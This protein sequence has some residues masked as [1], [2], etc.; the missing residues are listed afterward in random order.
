MSDNP[1][2]VRYRRGRSIES[3]HRGAV[4]LV[5]GDRITMQLGDPM[6]PCFIRSAAKPMQAAAAL[7]SGMGRTYGLSSQEIALLCASH[8]GEARHVDV[9]GRLLQR[10]GLRVEALQCATHVPLARH[11]IEELARH[12]ATPTPLH[13]N[14]SGKH[15][16]MLLFAKHLGADTSRYLDLE[17]PIQLRIRDVITR[18]CRLGPPFPEV[19][20]DGCSAPTFRIPL[21]S[22][23]LGFARVANPTH[24]DEDL[25]DALTQVRDA[26]LAHPEMVAGENRFD[27][28]LMR[29]AN[30]RALSK[31]GAEGVVGCG[32][33]GRNIGIAVRIDD[34]SSRAYE[35]L[36]P[37]LLERAGA[38]VQDDLRALA[39]Y[40]DPVLRNHAGTEVGAVEVAI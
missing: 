23:A 36:L 20:I 13:H 37:L 35:A 18:L 39:R 10:G 14:C 4:V 12:R 9:V 32:L 40:C 24:A 7:S 27:T 17:H 28:D 5:E 25:R 34:G 33:P 1:V 19:A 31:I 11:V 38:L 26:M 8:N 21:V 29:I 16:G 3:S 2:L 15:A 22:L 30:G 6:R